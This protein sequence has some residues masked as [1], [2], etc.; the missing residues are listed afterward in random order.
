MGEDPDSRAKVVTRTPTPFRFKPFSTL[1]IA[2]NIRSLACGIWCVH[3]GREVQDPRAPWHRILPV[4]PWP[5]KAWRFRAPLACS[6]PCPCY[7]SPVDDR[8]DASLINL[9]I[10]KR[11]RTAALEREAVV[12]GRLV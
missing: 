2:F 12:A 11:A 6:R 8:L 9:I 10:Y 7:P 5:R 3:A 1:S 4:P